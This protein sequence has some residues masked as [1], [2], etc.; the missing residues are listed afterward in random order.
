[1]DLFARA[2]SQTE[3]G[4]ER[5][6]IPSTSTGKPSSARASN[7]PNPLTPG[8]AVEVGDVGRG[9]F[10]SGGGPVRPANEVGENS[11]A[12][13]AAAATLYNCN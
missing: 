13:V 10:D 5:E 12:A 8:P 4:P 11:E 1:M 2:V 6:T 3:S 9:I 7:G